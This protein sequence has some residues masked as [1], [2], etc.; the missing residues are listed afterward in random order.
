MFRSFFRPQAAPGSGIIQPEALQQR[1]ETDDD[2]VLVD[3][4]SAEEY[5]HDGHIAGSRLLPLFT[6]PLRYHELPKD[7][8]IV[9]VCRSGARSQVACEQ[10]KQLGFTNTINLQGGLIGWRRAGLPV[11]Y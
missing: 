2:V 4:R 3:V 11:A 6:V 7:K 5:A 9:C 8:P 10:L 1:L